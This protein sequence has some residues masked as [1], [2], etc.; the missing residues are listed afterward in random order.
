MIYL[1][2]EAEESARQAHERYRAMQRMLEVIST[3][4][5]ERLLKTS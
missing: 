1:P 4:S 2:K 3:A 5:I